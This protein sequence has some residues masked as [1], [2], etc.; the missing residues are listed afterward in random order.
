MEALDR[1]FGT[2]SMKQ[3]KVCPRCAS[4]V[5]AKMRVCSHCGGRLPQRTLFQ[6]Y[7]SSHR[8]CPVCDTVLADSMKYCPHCGTKRTAVIKGLEGKEGNK[9]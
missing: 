4:M 5:P 2:E 1:E 7:Q 3:T 9:A 6:L 8:L